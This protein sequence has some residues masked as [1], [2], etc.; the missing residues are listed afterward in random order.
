MIVRAVPRGTGA[1]GRGVGRP[2]KI[3]EL[4][5]KKMKKECIFWKFS[6]AAGCSC[7]LIFLCQIAGKCSEIANNSVNS[8]NFR[9]RRAA[10]SSS[11][12]IFLNQIVGKCPKIANDVVIYENFGLRRAVYIFFKKFPGASPPSPHRGFAPGPRWGLR[13]QTPVIM[14][15]TLRVR[16]W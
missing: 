6:P 15:R 1:G 2:P 3:F 4:P 5:P 14:P 12:L 7:L 13:P 16:P 10:E 11:V 9:L 8:K